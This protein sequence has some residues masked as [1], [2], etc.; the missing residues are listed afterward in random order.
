LS[1]IKIQ[2]LKRKGG[3]KIRIHYTI[4][5]LVRLD[6]VRQVFQ[7]AVSANPL[8]RM[9]KTFGHREEG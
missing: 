9:N 2:K 5:S 4:A 8:S 1:G 7:G 3:W 6:A